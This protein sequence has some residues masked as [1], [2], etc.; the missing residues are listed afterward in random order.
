MFM[1]KV[2]IKGVLR[3]SMLDYPGRLASVIF[4]SR[5]NFRCSFC[6]NPELILE[7]ESLPSIKEE[8]FFKMLEERKGWVEAVV[9]SGGEP[10]LHEGLPEF[11]KR[12]KDLGLKVKLDTNGTNPK[13]LKGL[14]DENLLD[15]VAMDIKTSKE[16]YG[17]L[18][19]N[20]TCLPLVEESVAMLKQAKVETEFRTTAVPGLF[21]E[22]IAGEIAEW[23]KGA[24]S[25][26]LQQFNSENLMVDKSLLNHKAFSPDEIKRFSEIFKPFVEKVAVRGI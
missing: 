9:V 8:E 1:S 2:D 4:L 11:I 7:P 12:L 20:Q 22:K 14:L 19:G 24:K 23:L 21:D 18:T 16:E 5:C 17:N 13:M 3:T 26:A 6:H 25:F 15:F 10:T